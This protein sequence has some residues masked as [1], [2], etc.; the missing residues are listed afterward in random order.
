MSSYFV[1]NSLLFLVLNDRSTVA[2]IMGNVKYKIK[3]VHT[4]GY[5]VIKEER[6]INN[7]SAIYFVVFDL[8]NIVS[9][10]HNRKDS[11]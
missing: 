6:S 9:S 4:S 11:I 5:V 2:T 1:N 8:V 10:K 3:A 7:V